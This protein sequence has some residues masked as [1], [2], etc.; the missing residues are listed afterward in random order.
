MDAEICLVGYALNPKKMRKSSKE[1]IHRQ[2]VDGS[3]SSSQGKKTEVEWCGGGLA[4][5][6]E[7]NADPVIDGVQFFPWDQDIPPLQ[8]PYFDILIHKLTEDIDRPESREKMSAL[9]SYLDTHPRTVVID[10][11]DS[12]R[13]VISRA[14]TCSFLERSIDRQRQMLRSALLPANHSIHHSSTTSNDGLNSLESEISSSTENK[15]TV[16]LTNAAE[17]SPRDHSSTS[18]CSSSTPISSVP[19]SSS[20]Y[21]VPFQ[22]PRYL[23]V[24]VDEAAVNGKNERVDPFRLSTKERVRIERELQE[25]DI[26]FPVICKPI[27]ACGTPL[28]HKMVVIVSPLDLD[29][30]LPVWPCVVQQYYDHGAV[31]YKAYVIDGSVMVFQRPS[32]PDLQ[33]R[34][35][36]AAAAAATVAARRQAGVPSQE[37]FVAALLDNP[38]PTADA[39]ISSSPKKRNVHNEK[40]IPKPPLIP[41]PLPSSPNIRHVRSVAFDSRKNY[42]TLQ[43]FLSSSNISSSDDKNA[44]KGGNSGVPNNKTVWWLPPGAVQRTKNE[45][46]AYGTFSNGV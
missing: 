6:L 11:V 37:A 24:G 45:I 10:P 46:P 38:T 39:N 31:L 35:Q 30:L 28:S 9:Q 8:Q 5:I 33:P 15:N 42:P 25:R 2:A 34:L 22:Q 29:L 14:R 4:D 43:D 32:L 27:E 3:S 16:S 36:E 40:S 17:E 20:S 26:C 13:M 12:V 44:D 21:R 41:F 23:L 1:L 18:A 19:S 7:N